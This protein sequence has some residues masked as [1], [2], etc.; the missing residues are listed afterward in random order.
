MMEL[1]VPESPNQVKLACDASNPTITVTDGSGTLD[2][3]AQ[4][5]AFSGHQLPM[6]WRDNDTV[7]DYSPSELHRYWN[8]V[9][10]YELT[11]ENDEGEKATQSFANQVC[12][13]ATMPGRGSE[14]LGRLFMLG[15]QHQQTTFLYLCTTH[16]Q[17]ELRAHL[18]KSMDPSE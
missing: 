16:P 15:T 18:L 4:K 14:T 1:T 6:K 5:V 2:I 11:D 8:K 7:K 13:E 9:A 10:Y 3:T 17:G 12:Q